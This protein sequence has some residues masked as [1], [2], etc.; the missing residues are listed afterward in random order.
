MRCICKP[1]LPTKHDKANLKRAF[2]LFSKE[3]IEEADGKTKSIL[4]GLCY[5]HGL[6]LERKLFGPLGY[7]MMYPFAVGD[8][9]DR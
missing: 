7:N 5:F 4:F 3:K 9:R 2:C 6:M 8:L 1:V